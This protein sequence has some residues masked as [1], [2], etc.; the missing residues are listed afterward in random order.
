[1]PLSAPLPHILVKLLW[2]SPI[3]SSFA[4]IS[5]KAKGHLKYLLHGVLGPWLSQEMRLQAG[6]MGHGGRKTSFKEEFH[7]EGLRIVLR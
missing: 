5:A 7:K 2:S 6:D 4:A 1:M 3:F